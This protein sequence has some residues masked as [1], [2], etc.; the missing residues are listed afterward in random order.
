MPGAMLEIIMGT[1]K[2]L[3]RPGPRSAITWQVSSSK[4]RPP[5]PQPTTTPVPSAVVSSMVRRCVFQGHAG[6]GTGKGG[7][8][9]G[10]GGQLARQKIV[11]HKPLDLSGDAGLKAGGI[12]AGDR[13]D[14]GSAAAKAVPGRS[15][16]DPQRGDQS[17]SGYDDPLPHGHPLLPMRRRV[18]PAGIGSGRRPCSGF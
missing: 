2:G 16:A 15:G 9:V 14:A 18:S 6:R 1:K 11:G 12:E 5:I 7:E 3:T 13:P 4:E 8:E 10:F 17:N